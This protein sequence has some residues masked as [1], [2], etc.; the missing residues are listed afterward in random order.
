MEFLGLS[1]IKCPNG[2][3]CHVTMMSYTTSLK[4]SYRYYGLTY[5]L[6]I[7]L[8]QPFSTGD[9]DTNDIVYLVKSHKVNSIKI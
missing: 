5:P 2:L 7:C 8:S 4:I 1:H 9:Q 6:K 3:F